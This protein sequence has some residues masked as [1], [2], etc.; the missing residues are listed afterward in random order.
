MSLL[1]EV[2]SLAVDD[3]MPPYDAA[4]ERDMHISRIV[5]RML[6]C[7]GSPH[8]I[9][10]VLCAMKK[11][12]VLTNMPENF[13]DET[14]VK[15]YS[16][17]GTALRGRGYGIQ[18][19]ELADEAYISSFDHE[20][21]VRGGEKKVLGTSFSPRPA[22]DILRATYLGAGS[23]DDP[24]A[25]K[26]LIDRIEHELYTNNPVI[27]Q[28]LLYKD[29]LHKQGPRLGTMGT[30][31][32]GEL[33]MVAVGFSRKYIIMHHSLGRAQW[34]H[35]D[36]STLYAKILEGKTPSTHVISLPDFSAINAAVRDQTV[37]KID[38]GDINIWDIL[39]FKGFVRKFDP[40][41]GKESWRFAPMCKIRVEKEMA[42]VA[43]YHNI[44]R[45]GTHGFFTFVHGG[46]SVN[47]QKDILA[48]KSFP[49]VFKKP[50]RFYISLR[51]IG[52]MDTGF[53]YLDKS[54][55]QC[56]PCVSIQEIETK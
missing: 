37:H 25:R 55:M 36:G 47:A 15:L 23:E 29:W 1:G 26:N 12:A 53:F 10:V 18:L 33:S 50:N 19:E 27:M 5:S 16:K 24:A 48:G 11:D 40:E 6:S 32:H 4:T 54:T 49:D 46:D 17:G 42:Q 34:L 52:D 28:I 43:C 9:H 45:T 31:V 7:K 35:P 44:Y 13:S 30:D 8:L 20:K 38:L 14:D 51:M 22:K 2:P 3:V 41:T 56:G 21:D 39:E